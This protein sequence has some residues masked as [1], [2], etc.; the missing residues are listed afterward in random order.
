MEG[1]PATISEA[2]I[3]KH[4]IDPDG[5]CIL[6]LQENATREVISLVASAEEPSDDNPFHE[7]VVEVIKHVQVQ[8]SSR[9]LMLASPVFRAMLHENNRFKEGEELL[10]KGNVEIDLEDDKP[11]SFVILMNVIHGRS[12]K[13][14][15]V[16]NL[17]TL[18]AIALLV[19]KYQMH[20]AGKMCSHIWIKSIHKIGALY[21]RYLVRQGE[22]RTV[23]FSLSDAQLTEHIYWLCI[24]WVFDNEDVFERVTSNLIGEIEFDGQLSMA[25]LKEKLVIPMPD[26]IIGKPASVS[27]FSDAKFANISLSCHRETARKT[28]MRC[29]RT[30]CR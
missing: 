5:D 8:V 19:D 26:S 22:N 6:H 25:I 30:V 18:H 9:H 11:H 4:T 20:D 13:L 15:E 24:A 17:K 10:S 14:P 27:S 1:S 28:Y 12:S 23:N 16:V 7:P 3:E 29:D 21:P 2:R